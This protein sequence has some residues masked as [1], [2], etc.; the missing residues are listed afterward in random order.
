MAGIIL[1]NYGFLKEDPNVKY[2][3]LTE[4][5]LLVFDSVSDFDNRKKPLKL[6]DIKSIKQVK[7]TTH[8]DKMSFLELKS[9]NE[10]ITLLASN[11]V[12][13]I[14]VQVLN[15]I[16]Q[17]TPL[18]E[19]V[20]LIDVVKDQ[21][22]SNSNGSQEQKQSKKGS[23]LKTPRNRE[24]QHEFKLLKETESNTQLEMRKDVVLQFVSKV[25]DRRLSF[26]ELK[27]VKLILEF[28][29]KISRREV[30]LLQM[31]SSEQI[32]IVNSIFSDIEMY[33]EI[34]ITINSIDIV[35]NI[36]TALLDLIL[37][38]FELYVLPKA[39]YKSIQGLDAVIGWTINSLSQV[40]IP[41]DNFNDSFSDGIA[42]SNL[43]A[44]HRPELKYMLSLDSTSITVLIY[45]LLIPS[46]QK[47]HE[48]Y[49]T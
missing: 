5:D 3:V 48:H 9:D 39:H 29:K 18:S 26:D 34:P 7:N 6:I 16:L 49:I 30:E 11:T 36:D 10:C 37:I 47:S 8:T 25:V 44:L 27:D 35:N 2:W 42:F 13:A 33:S 21:E 20:D 46:T 43:I 22:A 17:D 41:I 12:I 19:I 31:G 32:K 4:E 1:T 24:K 38:I 23:F 15:L 45:S 14:W 40:D 28:Y